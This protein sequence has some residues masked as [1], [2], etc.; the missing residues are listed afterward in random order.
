MSRQESVER[1]LF[2]PKKA[3]KPDYEAR[4][5]NGATCRSPGPVYCDS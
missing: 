2:F 4:R 3:M 5:L 1:G